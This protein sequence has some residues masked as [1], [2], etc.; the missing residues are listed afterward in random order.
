MHQARAH[1]REPLAYALLISRTSP[2]E[3]LLLVDGVLRIPMET[4]DCRHLGAT[5]S[6]INERNMFCFCCG[7]KSPLPQ[8]SRSIRIPS[9]ALSQY[10]YRQCT[11]KS[12]ARVDANRLR[13]QCLEVERVGNLGLSL[14]SLRRAQTGLLEVL[15]KR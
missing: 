6:F 4:G 9:V 14:N 1:L 10:P 5:W 15:A 7:N 8:G 3:K 12:R 2:M 11:G 13:F